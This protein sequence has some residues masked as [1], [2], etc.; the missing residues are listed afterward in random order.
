MAISHRLHSPMD[1]RPDDKLEETPKKIVFLSVE[2]ETEKDYFTHIHNY[3]QAL[4]I[5]TIVHIETLSKLTRDGKSDPNQ[6]FELLQEFLK[7]RS[8]GILPQDVYDVLNDDTVNYSLEYISKYLNG[9][10]SDKDAQK[11][12]YAIKMAGIDLDYQKFLSEYKG[13]DNNDV[14]AVVI[15]RDS[16]SHSEKTLKELFK[17]CSSKNCYCFITNPCFE[18]W[19]L[20]HISDVIN[21]YDGRFDELKKNNKISS[22]HTFVSKEVSEKARH[23]KDISENIF[24]KH[25]LPNV[26]LAIERV[27]DFKQN[28]EELLNSLGSNLPKL[29]SLLR[30]KM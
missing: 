26:D 5:E 28:E 9:E 6:V 4:G 23:R 24:K 1:V 10:L 25:Y 7:I 16:G 8:E 27:S 20:L 22:R 21:E 29:F 2:G 13:E 18:F 12:Q 30:N 17:K 15:D 14:F 11:L 19:L 3:R